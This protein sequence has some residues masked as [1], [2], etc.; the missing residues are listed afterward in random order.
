MTAVEPRP[1]RIRVRT[2][3][4]VVLGAPFLLGV[5]LCAV[6]LNTRSL[7]LDEG[8]TVAITSQHGAALWSGIA[9][10]GGNMLLYYLLIHLVGLIFGQATWVLRLPSLLATATTGALVAALG[11]RLLGDR[12]QSLIAGMLTMVSLPLV[13]WGQDARGYALMVA[14]CTASMLSYVCVLGIGGADEPAASG[15]S[16]SVIAYVLTTAAALYVGYD[17]GLVLFGQLALL[18]LYRERAPVVFRA[19]AAVVLLCVPLLI[20]ALERGSGQLFWVPPINSAVLGQSALTLMSAGMPPNFHYTATT[21]ITVGLSGLVLLGALGLVAQVARRSAD[22]RRHMQLW[23]LVTWLLAPMVVALLAYAAGEPVE[24]ARCS[25]LLMPAISLLIVW[26]LTQPPVPLWAGAGVIVALTVLR[27]VQVLPTYGVSPEGWKGAVAYVQA[28]DH[29]R[30][31]CA[32]FYPQDGRQV[33]DYYMT[34]EG[35]GI[36]AALRPML[37]S[38]PWGQARPYVERYGTLD[39][40]Q[41]RSV[42]SSCA[43]V[44]LVASHVGQS[45]GPAGSRAHLQGYRELQ[46]SL[47]GRYPVHSVRQF[48][49]AAPVYVTEYS[50]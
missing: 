32:V 47:A 25:I 24:L 20:L 45:N 27:L 15:L 43:R 46:A 33:F 21:V 14:F 50:R 19:L 1:A 28:V 26:A 4:I 8:A 6:E 41:L 29:D 3:L 13:F 42:S 17:A 18:A 30:P 9:H 2:D 48:G 37:P 39:P 35:D 34:R 11:L 7:W 31:A 49:W 23:V 44:F 38:L 36:A 12:R 10:D 22:R 5:L 16:R 40:S